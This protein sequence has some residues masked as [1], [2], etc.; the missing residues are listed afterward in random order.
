MSNIDPIESKIQLEV[1]K[2]RLK[3]AEEKITQLEVV[4][5]QT[6]RDLGK[7]DADIEQLRD[8]RDSLRIKWEVL[9][10]DYKHAQE[11]I[12]VDNKKT[13]K[14]N[15]RAKFQAFLALLIFLLS[16]ILVN[17][18]TTMLTAS[19]PNPLWQAMI[20]LAIAA[21]IVGGLMTTLLALEGGK[22]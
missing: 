15:N 10:R 21:Y 18:G 12:N 11:T 16:T 4:I 8:D 19:P 1:M 13:N 20:G 5:A 2:E 9:Q 7:K 6:N 22:S 3:Y 17:I 14:K